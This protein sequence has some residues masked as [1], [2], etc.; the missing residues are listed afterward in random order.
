[1]SLPIIGDLRPWADPT[2]THLRRLPMHVPLTGGRRR[3]LDGTWR[4]EMFDRPDDVPAAALRGVRRRAVNVDVPGNWTMQDLGGFVD[5]PHYTNVQ[6][7]FPGAPPA[8]PERNPTGVYRRDVRIPAAWRRQQVVLSIGGAESVHAV[9]VNSVF[10]GYG[11]DSR[12]PSEYD[13]TAACVDGDNE[14]AVVVM[15]Y[16]AHSH[17]EDQDNWWMAGLHRSVEVICRP[18]TAI[19]D[20]P[21]RVDLDDDGVG[22][23]DVTTAVTTIDTLG[24][25]WTVHTRLLDPDGDVIASD[26][27]PIPHRYDRPYVFTGHQCTSRFAV[28]AVQ[29]W[30][31]ETPTRYCVEVVLCD[32]RGRPV[33]DATQHIGFRTVRVA[34]RALL[35]NGEPVRICGVNRH[36][37]H[38]DRGSAVTTDDIRDDL[39]AMRRHNI[40]AIRTAHYP[41][42]DALY[43]LCDELGFYVIDEANI[44]C[45]AHNRSLSDRDDYLAAWV[46]RGARMVTRDRN[47]PCIIMWSLGNES[48]LGTGHHALAGWIRRADPTRPLHYEDALRLEGW[49]DGGREVTDVVCPMYPSVDDIVAY[50]NSDADRPLIMCE[51][52]HAMG[53][54]NGGLADYWAAIDSCD[55]LQGG[56]IWEWKDHGLRQT[57]P[58]GRAV[59]AYGGQFGDTPHD[60]NFVADG[61]MSSD[62]VPHPALREVAW[63][64]RPV[65]TVRA[66][67]GGRPRLLI[68]NRRSFTDMGDLAGSWTYLVDGHVLRHGRLRVGAVPAGVTTEIDVPVTI[69]DDDADHRLHIT[70]HTAVDE[71]FARAGHLVA[72]DE[73]VLRERVTSVMRD[74]TEPD[75]R[76]VV[77]M[78]DTTG[79]DD[80][81]GPELWVMRAPTDNDGFRLMPDLA[82]RLGVGGQAWRRW[83]TSG[84]VTGRV[85]DMMTATSTAMA[86]GEPG[87]HG[88]VHQHRIVINDD[89]ADLP[90]VG[91]R[92]RLGLGFTR[93]RWWGRGPHENYPD[94][95]S[96]ALLGVWETDLDELPYLVPQDYGLRTDCRW[97]EVIDASTGDIVRFDQFSRPLHIAVVGHDV[98]ELIAADAA[99]ALAPRSGVWVHLDVAHRGLGTASCGPDVAERYRIPAGEYVWSY[100]MTTLRSRRP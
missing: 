96:S 40:N 11:T 68:T 93:M 19:A 77:E 4:L 85:A 92:W 36:D 66:E 3:C 100:R 88:I 59:L 65:T 81:V 2:I 34:G 62:L 75:A 47:H 18:R 41:N 25:G 22:H 30:S 46:E 50:A 54:S 57:L 32:P 63:V 9:F 14:I 24:A 1:M 15:R 83:N 23:A 7:P 43:D 71:W 10:V 44:E 12:L 35:V 6:M 28:P 53:N 45:H 91:A 5:R 58:D 97:L 8:V 90:R 99:H 13:I 80:V 72:W 26:T 56:F 82:E 31:A 84:L 49:A 51:Y 86:D 67:R 89:H 55:G 76:G 37:Q 70:W 69:A 94:R 17:I 78:G 33:D 38:P 52:S 64:H 87:Q 29:P 27:Q 74:A 16:S 42:A 98:A 61:L 79:R 20:V 39:V 21:I 73:V 48:G 95:S 60:G